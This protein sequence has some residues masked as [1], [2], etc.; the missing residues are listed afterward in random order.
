MSTVI[1]TPAGPLQVIKP[2]EA[3]VEAFSRVWPLPVL[4]K[5]PREDASDPSNARATFILPFAHEG[6]QV[7]M[8]WFPEIPFPAEMAEVRAMRH[9]ELTARVVA[10]CA[11]HGFRGLALPLCTLRRWG[12][13]A[14]PG[15]G[16]VAGPPPEGPPG[17][18][19]LP[20]AL[21]AL[22]AAIRAGHDY[23]STGAPKVVP[24]SAVGALHLDFALFD[25]HLV[26]FHPQLDPRHPDFTLLA[27][28]GF[29][30]F[31]HM[32]V[33]STEFP[34]LGERVQPPP[35]LER[36]T[37]LSANGIRR[38][39]RLMAHMACCD[40]EYD[41]REQKVLEEFL[42]SFPIPAA[43]AEQLMLEGQRGENLSVGKNPVERELL[44]RLLLDVAAADGVLDKAE[45]KRL[46]SLGKKIGIST[47]DL[48]HRLLERFAPSATPGEAKPER[49]SSTRGARRIYRLLWNLAASD[50][51]VNDDEE[52]LLEQFRVTMGIDQAE[53]TELRNEG[54][55]GTN[56]QVGKSES[57]RQLL[58]EQLIALAVADGDVSTAELKR[59]RSFAS[60]LK[61]PPHA[62]E[63]RL[64]ATIGENRPPPSATGVVPVPPELHEGERA[65]LVL[66]DMPAGVL[67]LD[68]FQTPVSQGFLGFR[69]LE[70]GAHRVALH[71]DDGEVSCWVRL[72][73]GAVEVLTFAG[74][75]LHP[76]GA[77][78]RAQYEAASRRGDLDEQLAPGPKNFAW[79]ELT[80][81]L[82]D[83]AF[84]PELKPIPRPLPTSRLEH[85]LLETHDG[86]SAELLA[87]LAYSFLRGTLDD[88]ALARERWTY[89]VQAFYH[90]GELLPKRI[91]NMFCWG[92]RLLRAQMR[93]VPASLLGPDSALTF[94]SHYLSEDLIDT[95]VEELVEA[96]LQ[97]AT[98]IAGYH[99]GA[100]EPPALPRSLREPEP[101]PPDHPFAQGLAENARDIA[102]TEQS[103][104]RDHPDLILL[105]SYRTNIQE[106][107]GDILGALATQERMVA[108]GER[109]RTPP[110]QLAKGYGRLARLYRE[111]GRRSDAVAA[112][113]RGHELAIHAANL[114]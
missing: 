113:R 76:A 44:F 80:E 72:E 20:V 101:L 30:G 59:L 3:W 10:A 24:A 62:L 52:R 37:R 33:E 45:K 22:R 75:V 99:A 104:G 48:R 91:P 29:K 100:P 89:L 111:A 23:E 8:S 21:D 66:L 4:T 73:A 87:E 50:G 114:N 11:A 32:P 40:G 110:E 43:E 70:P 107:A 84:P 97:W 61:V 55:R 106:F 112:E 6:T 56:L 63:A 31:V 51:D 16:L 68:F 35:P 49:A 54:L 14:V 92:V 74:G 86:K 27:D 42:E 34:Q 95:E 96:G 77:K 67:A 19:P 15:V 39:Y 82:L 36:S 58:L 90:C 60:M 69:D 53:A 2:T 93:E 98:F 1:E 28:A 105:L 38:I 94:G 88:D 81:P 13:V 102:A 85:A 25:G 109:H 26:C 17:E 78:R 103:Q 18:S 108:L 46:A 65:Q 12:D 5:L 71:L 64:R 7:S 57:E 9:R 41:P 47:E 79:S 83:V